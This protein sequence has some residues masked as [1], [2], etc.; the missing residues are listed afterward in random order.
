VEGKRQWGEKKR[1]RKVKERGKGEKKNTVRSQN[2][3]KNFRGL[4]EESKK[5]RGRYGN[6]PGAW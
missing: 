2:T 5:K 6:F 4:R 3:T 1:E